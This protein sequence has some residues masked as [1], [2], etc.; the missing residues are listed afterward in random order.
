MLASDMDF[1]LHLVYF[2][3]SVYNESM[4]EPKSEKQ[5]LKKNVK[6]KIY[7]NVAYK[8]VKQFRKTVLFWYVFYII[9]KWCVNL[10]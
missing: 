2:R 4:F 3:K 6:L 8:L 5:T 1:W 9:H 7:S 10:I